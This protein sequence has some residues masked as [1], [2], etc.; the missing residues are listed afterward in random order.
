[1]LHL[2]HNG[3]LLLFPLVLE[4]GAALS[5]QKALGPVICFSDFCKGH[6][7]RLKKSLES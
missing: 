3:F 7:C 4:V 6:L 2:L 5:M 1:M